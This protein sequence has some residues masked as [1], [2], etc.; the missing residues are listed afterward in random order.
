MSNPDVFSFALTGDTIISRRLSVYREPEFLAL[1][2][3]LR[4]AD[5]AFTNLEVLFHDY[6]PYP[7]SE[8][9]GTYMRA[10]PALARELVWAGFDMVARANNHAADYGVHG[11][12]LTTEHVTKAGLVQAGVGEALTEA[13]EA[14]FLETPNGRVALVSAASTYPDHARAGRTRGDM[15]ARPGLSPLRF[16]TTHVATRDQLD[17]LRRL[18]DELGLKPP[19][20]KLVSPT[21]LVPVGSDREGEDS[22]LFFGQRFIIGDAPEI[23]TE[24]RQEDLDEIAAVVRN[25]ARL[26]DYTLV[27]LH[28][29]EGSGGSKFTPAR[30]LITAA[31]ALVEAG[32]D[33][34][35]CQGPHV[36]RAV[37]VYYGKPILYGLGN[38]MMQNDT[39]LRLPPE[40]YEPYS[41]GANAH[42]A[43]FNDHRYDFDRAG[44][45]TQPEIWE[46]AVAM[47]RWEGKRLSELVLHPVSLG[48]GKPRP[49]RGRPMI[50]DA[51]LARK[52]V[53]DVARL[54]REPFGTEIV[55]RDGLGIVRIPEVAAA[56]VAPSAESTETPG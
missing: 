26:S 8:A 11:M 51:Q 23:R 16:K 53:E 10:D 55:F 15:P 54:S 18:R 22:L 27:S 6:E 21:P 37:E 50:A 28:S 31:R 52:I 5:V 1:I 4:G 29:H 12:R 45:P 24:P 3:L 36:L 7:M 25:A 19:E 14:R 13:R 56:G 47:V 2:D 43:D 9:G 39:M 44:F 17:R 48:F 49:H 33:I 34:V 42:V 46:S 32:A 20:P 41:L 30:F 35:I 40:N 38:F